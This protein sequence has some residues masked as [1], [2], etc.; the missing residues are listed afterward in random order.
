MFQQKII[1]GLVSRIAAGKGTTAKYLQDKYQ[2][3][4]YRFSTMLR[5]VLN[6]LYVPIR[7]EN[8][9]KLSTVLRQNFGE[10]LMAKVI[11]EDVKR[12]N[13][14]IIVVDGVRRLADIKYLKELPGFY[15]VAIETD[16]KIRYERLIKRSENEGDVNKPFEQFLQDEQGE[17]ERQIPEVM[18]QADYK[19]NN[20]GSY[21]ELYAQIDELISKLS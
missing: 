5:D 8:M 13:N 2:A 18:S 14:K 3:S 1:I 16:Q 10:D 12:D 11:A 4:I 9:Q 7:R 15:L 17:A 6:R 20:N 21:E 19:F